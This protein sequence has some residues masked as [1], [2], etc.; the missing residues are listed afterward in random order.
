[1]NT[2]IDSHI[3]M[4]KVFIF[5]FTVKALWLKLLREWFLALGSIRAE[6]RFGV[7][8]EDKKILRSYT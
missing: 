1:M 6:L 4:P 3:S 2:F 7:C 8:R 5:L